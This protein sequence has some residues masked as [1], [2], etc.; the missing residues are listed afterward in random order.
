M[1]RQ[2]FWEPANDGRRPARPASGASGVRKKTP[3]I[4][5]W[6][7]VAQE[8]VDVSFSG[9]WKPQYLPVLSLDVE[10]VLRIS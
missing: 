3:A 5:G 7:S 4:A 6:R 10:H 9:A 1:R 8:P 2:H